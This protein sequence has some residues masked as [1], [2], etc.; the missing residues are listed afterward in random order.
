MLSLMRKKSL[1][2]GSSTKIEPKQGVGANMQGCE[3][4]RGVLHTKIRMCIISVIVIATVVIVIVV[5]VVIATVVFV[6]TDLPKELA[7]IV[8]CIIRSVCVAYDLEC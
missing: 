5:V 8:I 4:V 6:P 3:H 2:S 7:A 1:R